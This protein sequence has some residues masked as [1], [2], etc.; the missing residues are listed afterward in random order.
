MP[1]SKGFRHKHRT[2]L[3]QWPLAQYAETESLFRHLYINIGA[4]HTFPTFALIH[5]SQDTVLVKF[6]GVVPDRRVERWVGQ[7][8]ITFP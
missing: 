5:T 6:R 8:L 1:P 2:T 7:I 3:A 4:V